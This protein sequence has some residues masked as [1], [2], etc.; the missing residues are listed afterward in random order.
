LGGGV[1]AEGV[2]HGN[3]ECANARMRSVECGMLSAECCVR[4]VGCGVRNAEW[5]WKMRM[6]M[7]G[8][9]DG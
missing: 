6:R 4:N 3:A 1:G 8:E 5:E 2:F 7:G 9:N